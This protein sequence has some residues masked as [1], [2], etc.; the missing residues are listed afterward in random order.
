MFA[1]ECSAGISKLP[2]AAPGAGGQARALQT[3]VRL[4]RSVFEDMLGTTWKKFGTVSFGK[5]ESI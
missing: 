3:I 5:A 1:G 4:A 2:V